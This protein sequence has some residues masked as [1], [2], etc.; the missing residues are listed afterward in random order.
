MSVV[1][2]HRD[3]ART[4]RQARTTSSISGSRRGQAPGDGA[5]GD[6]ASS[7]TGRDGAAGLPR[8]HTDTEAWGRFAVLS[9]T[10][11]EADG[12]VEPER[13]GEVNNRGTQAVAIASGGSPG[14]SYGTARSQEEA[15]PSLSI[16]EAS[17]S[18]SG[19][20]PAPAAENGTNAGPSNS[21][22]RRS[23]GSGETGN[24]GTKRRRKRTDF[25][26]RAAPTLLQ[27]YGRLE[28]LLFTEATSHIQHAEEPDRRDGPCPLVAQM[29]VRRREDF[30][31][32]ALG[33]ETAAA[34][35]GALKELH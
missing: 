34:I 18:S 32:A 10:D 33:I 23:Q 24:S 6:G 7:Y 29:L 35:T 20:A 31:K 12:G 16:G 11:G 28:L 30:A 17:S 13:S 21:A 8:A 14:P 26:Q 4:V 22:P 19:E 27:L 3:M 25:I 15:S 1:S 5:S 2:F 9:G